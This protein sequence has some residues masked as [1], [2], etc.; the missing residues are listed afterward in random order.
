MRLPHRLH[1]CPQ[2]GSETKNGVYCSLK[3]KD[4]AQRDAY[5]PKGPFGAMLYEDFVK[6][7]CGRNW[8]EAERRLAVSRRWI[9]AICSGAVPAWQTA[10]AIIRAAEKSS[11]YL[12][13]EW[14][15]AYLRSVGDAMG[16]VP[17]PGPLP[18]DKTCEVCGEGFSPVGAQ[19]YCSTKCRQLASTRRWRGQVVAGPPQQGSRRAL[20]TWQI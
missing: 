3:C 16:G 12:R 5:E 10:Q 15:R 9:V 7:Q 2:C 1:D 17:E 14:M 20:A 8:R 18:G 19:I 6:R 13:S 11:E 4:D